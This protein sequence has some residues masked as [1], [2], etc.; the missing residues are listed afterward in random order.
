MFIHTLINTFDKWTSSSQ[1]K[2]LKKIYV[3]VFTLICVGKNCIGAVALMRIAINVVCNFYYVLNFEQ[4]NSCTK[5]RTLEE[6]F[7]LVSRLKW[8]KKH[9]IQESG[10]LPLSD[11][12]VS[13]SAVVKTIFVLKFSD[14]ISI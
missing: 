11:T 8:L 13:Q 5:Y 4:K 2:Q 1:R 6:T 14:S 12:A 10:T 7:K 9:P 3:L